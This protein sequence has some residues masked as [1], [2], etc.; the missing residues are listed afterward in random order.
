MKLLMNTNI[1]ELLWEVE[2]VPQAYKVLKNRQTPPVIVHAALAT[3]CKLATD[4]H[5]NTKPVHVSPSGQG[6]H[7]YET[8]MTRGGRI[9]WEKAKQF[10][11]HCSRDAKEIIFRHVIRVWDI[12]PQ[13]DKLNHKIDIC[14]QQMLDSYKK[15]LESR[16][17]YEIIPSDPNYDPDSPMPITF[18][19]KGTGKFEK[20]IPPAS[21][22]GDEFNIVPTYS[23]S[24]T[25][26]KCVLDDEAD[27]FDFP[28]RPYPDEYD[29]IRLPFETTVLLL[30]RSGTGKTTCLLH[31]LWKRFKYYWSPSG[32]GGCGMPARQRSLDIESAFCETFD[33]DSRSNDSVPMSEGIP[34]PAAIEATSLRSDIEH[35]RQVFVTKNHL[36]CRQLKHR[37][38]SYARSHSFLKEHASM[39]KQPQSLTEVSDHAY[40]LFLTSWQFFFLLDKS[41]GG[42]KFFWPSSKDATKVPTVIRED[43]DLDPNTL[44]E[45]EYEDETVGDTTSGLEASCTVPAQDSA[46]DAEK[47]PQEIVWIEVTALYFEKHIWRKIKKHSRKSLDPTL[48]WMEIKSFI[49]GSTQALSFQRPLTRDE[50]KKV[51]KK[52]APHYASERDDIYRLYEAYKHYCQN[53]VIHHAT[54]GSQARLFDEC[55]LVLSLYKRIYS[56]GNIP[57]LVHTF[58]IDEVQDFTQAELL[59]LFH[60]CQDPN[61]LFFTGDTAQ[62][63]KQGVSFR[64]D[65]LRTIF[66]KINK[67]Y[68][69]VQNPNVYELTVNFRSHAGILQ[70]SASVID[71]LSEFFKMSFDSHLPKD[72]GIFQG[73]IPVLLHT[74]EVDELALLLRSNKRESSPIEFGAHQ[75]IIVRS[76]EAR[77]SYKMCWRM[78]QRKCS[79]FMK[80]KAWS[81]MMC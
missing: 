14:K 28:Y 35:L 2:L 79:P 12:V 44:L 51:G 21:P 22:K 38:Y 57:W 36:L 64:F 42:R 60:C 68:P 56:S 40:P 29:I 43:Y 72:E 62:A 49:K 32:L 67:K 13:H 1:E 16:K 3:I 50:Y 17:L 26:L 65:F 4:I 74:C 7:L 37:F 52:L 80:Q 5:H 78:S 31:R 11:P 46:V 15:G 6:P 54:S 47:K 8:K 18:R 73:P 69:E 70:L 53:T 27:D 45:L 59:L 61:G 66:S 25:F 76:K 55:D 10:S 48:V 20:Y 58:Y 39:K 71:L 75:A 63:I 23:F 9:L 30:G 77:Q 81:L 41:L 24:T 33:A 19:I 34:N